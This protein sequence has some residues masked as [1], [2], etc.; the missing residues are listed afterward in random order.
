MAKY[1]VCA[2][3]IQAAIEFRV[4]LFKVYGDSALIIHRL[5][6]EWETRDHKLIPYQAHIR[7]LM[8][9]FDDIS[10]Y[11]IPREENQMANALVTLSSMFQVSP[12]GDLPCI[13]IT[14]HTEPA[15]YCLIKEEKNGKPW[16]FDIKRYIKDIE[17][18]HEASENDKRT[19]R[20]L[21]DNFFSNGV[22]LYKRK[23]D[24]VLL[25]C[26][27]ASEVEQILR[28]GHEGSFGTHANGHAM[29]RKILRAGYYW[30]TMENDCYIHVWK[31]QKCQAFPDNVKASS[32]PLNVLS[33]PWLFSMWGHRC[34]WGH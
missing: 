33:A 9:R 34:D 21:V 27:D 5:K 7:E 17:Y 13:E 30:L 22:M 10:F 31:C 25:W 6:G 8:E 29:A 2:M 11:H 15:H 4:K 26:V 20:R 1:E 23:H 28:E 19:L 32:D 16:Y 14:C 18:P 24:M 12:H 3:G